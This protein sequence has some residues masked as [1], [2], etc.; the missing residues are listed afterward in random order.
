MITEKEILEESIALLEKYANRERASLSDWYY[1]TAMRVIGIA[2]CESEAHPF[3][4]KFLINL[5]SDKYNSQN[6]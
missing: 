4:L 5:L 3:V 1:P 2:L 6:I